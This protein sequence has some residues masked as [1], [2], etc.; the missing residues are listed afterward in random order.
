MEIIRFPLAVLLV[1]LLGDLG[2]TFLYHVPEHVFG[3]YHILVHHRHPKRSFI[4]YS[5][6]HQNPWALLN[7]ILNLLP[8]VIFVPLIWQISSHGAIAGLGLAKLHSLWR[9]QSE[10]KVI[11]PA[12]LQKFCA[13]FWIITPEQHWRHH[14]RGS[15]GYGDIFT[16]CDRPAQAWEKQ[17]RRWKF[18]G[19]QRAKRC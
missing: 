18:R 17:L 9:H 4:L 15:I 13:R 1:L 2:A 14:V 16:F 6:E 12:F 3:K 19:R 8:Y 10:G 5:L 11:T 7:G